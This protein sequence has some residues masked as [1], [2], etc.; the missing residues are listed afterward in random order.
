MPLHRTYHNKKIF[1]RA[2]PNQITSYMNKHH[3]QV[4]YK[5]K[6]QKKQERTMRG[7]SHVRAGTCMRAH[8]TY[9]NKKIFFR[10]NPNQITSYMNRHHTQAAYKQ[11]KHKNK[12]E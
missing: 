2:N 8:R 3:T 10:A 5:Q 12:K 1:F 7:A 6:K 9:H 11:K 4:A